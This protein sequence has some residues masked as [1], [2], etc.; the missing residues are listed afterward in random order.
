MEKIPKH[1]R[2]SLI[3]FL[4]ILWLTAIVMAMNLTSP[5]IAGPAGI[6]FVF[7]LFYFFS[8]STIYLILKLLLKLWVL[9]GRNSNFG[10]RKTMYLACVLALAPIFLVALNTLGEI[11]IVEVALVGLLV[12]LG[13]FYIVR[14]SSS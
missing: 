2:A 9:T 6:L 5:I 11:G 12:G 10:K 8:L 3:I 1:L 14:R 13:C 4:P 7:L